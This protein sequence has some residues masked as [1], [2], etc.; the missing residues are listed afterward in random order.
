MLNG[1][2]KYIL[3]SYFSQCQLFE[4]WRTLLASEWKWVHALHL[5]SKMVDGGGVGT[6]E[7]QLADRLCADWFA[8]RI[9]KSITHICG[10]CGNWVWKL[11]RWV[12]A[13]VVGV[14]RL[15]IL[16]VCGWVCLPVCECGMPQQLAAC[17][18]PPNVEV[19]RGWPSESRWQSGR[20][21]Y[22]C[23]Y[24]HNSCPS[25]CTTNSRAMVN[26]GVNEVSLFKQVIRT[27]KEFYSLKRKWYVQVSG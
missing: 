12:V 13:A 23:I 6:D 27:D 16:F 2:E 9:F 26:W 1:I 21:T 10:I 4:A 7:G 5:R 17:V 24:S 11:M 15:S 25:R 20:A 19:F 3:K 18:R 14:G 8:W 22:N